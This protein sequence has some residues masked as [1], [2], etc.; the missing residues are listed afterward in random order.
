MWEEVCILGHFFLR[1][2]HLLGIWRRQL[3][4]KN[5]LNLKTT[6]K[7][8]RKQKP[9][10]NKITALSKIETIK[11]SKWILLTYTDNKST[12]LAKT[13][14]KINKNIKIAYKT[15]KLNNISQV[16]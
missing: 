1:C 2:H 10:Q 11:H 16:K 5:G 7:L 13:I 4:L 8:I 12:G 3:S 14:R 15:N 9:K 6:H